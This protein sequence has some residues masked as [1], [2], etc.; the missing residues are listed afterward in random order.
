MG[1]G[2]R[3]AFVAL[4]GRLADAAGAVIRPYFRT[5][6]VIDE[7]PDTS[8]VTVADRESEA[9][10][11]AI[12]AAECPDHGILG[13]EYGSERVDADYV[14]VLDPI[15][16]TK[17]FIAGVPLFGTLIALLHHGRPVLGIIDQ[18]VLGERWL[19]VDGQATLFNGRPA[20]VRACPA[21]AEAILTTT[22]PDMFGGGD[23]DA[24]MRLRGAVKSTRYGYDCYGYAMLAMGF[25]DLIVEADLAPYDYCALIPVITGAGGVITDW[26]GEPLGL[27]SD[28]R[29]CAAGDPRVHSEAL[30]RLR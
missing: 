21:L 16:G 28:G 25:I 4:A 18:P 26:A 1:T 23:R 6:F 17:S 3:D 22:S 20:T 13:E 29:L 15:D 27:R 9:A 14:W 10:M 30:A 12:L 8:P 7:K 19:G 5:D 2:R 11:R 24:F